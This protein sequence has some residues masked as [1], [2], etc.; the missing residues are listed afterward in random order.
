MAMTKE[1]MIAAS[2]KAVKDKEDSSKNSGFTKNYE[3][4]AYAPCVDKSFAVWRFVG[5]TPYKRVS[6][7]DANV[8]N[9]ASVTG[10]DGKNYE[11]IFPDKKD[12]TSFLW[13]FT[14]KVLS[15]TEWDKTKPKGQ[16]KQFTYINQYPE[17]VNRI[18]HNGKKDY[19]QG[20]TGA[21]PLPH[22]MINVVDY[23]DDWCK[24]NKHTKLASKGKWVSKAG[25]EG[26]NKGM[27]GGFFDKILD[28]MIEPYGW[29]DEYQ[30]VVLQ[31]KD[32]GFDTYELYHIVNDAARLK[33]Y[34]IDKYVK[35]NFDD[36]ST[37][38]LYDIDK[39]FRV[40]TYHKIAKVWGLFIQE[41]DKKLGTEFYKELLDFVAIEKEEL[42]KLATNE[43]PTGSQEEVEAPKL[44]KETIVE[45]V[46]AKSTSRTPVREV[47]S[48]VK[49]AFDIMDYV[50]IFPAI[51]EMTAEDKSLVVGYDSVKED[52]IWKDGIDMFECSGPGCKKLTGS[53]SICPHCASKYE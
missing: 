32:K 22:L 20:D 33:K 21:L 28:K 10:D 8:V 42:A 38:E 19:K 45:K 31:D 15:Y 14:N 2:K 36:E 12:K 25:V 35:T 49:K 46:E 37:F 16:E 48:E 11:L 34:T 5:G 27:T 50:D 13:R 40:S 24:T 52:F 7:T 6:P 18:L 41:V 17:I 26:F 1:E 9:I 39:L 23:I 47:K 30:T 53:V 4:I 43:N 44:V 3:E 29:M 51:E